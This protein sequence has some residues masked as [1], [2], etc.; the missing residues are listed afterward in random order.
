MAGRNR[1]FSGRSQVRVVN[2]RQT[3]WEE[4]PGTLDGL[5]IST[6]TS[7]IL[8]SGQAAIGDGQTII[9]LRGFAELIITSAGS[10]AD[11]FTGAMG[12][13][14]VSAPAFAIGITAVP[15]P[16]TEIEWEGWMWHQMFSY[17]VSDA[18]LD[19]AAL[20]FTI[21]SKAMR[22]IGSE[23]VVFCAIETKDE[24]GAVNML[25]TV[26]TRMLAKLP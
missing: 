8:G 2:P 20:R 21:D 25:A 26:G 12:I 24:S 10:P 17:H 23:E 13:G 6:E 9:R 1:S 7:A 11:G 15:T 19:V 16:I 22:K 18:A 14:I 3:G 5:A 4:G